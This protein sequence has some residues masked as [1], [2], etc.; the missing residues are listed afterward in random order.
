MNKPRRVQ[1]FIPT[2]PPE[3]THNDL[4]A[5][6]TYANCKPVARIRKSDRLKAEEDRLRPYIAKIRPSEPLS[7]PLRVVWKLVW[8]TDGKHTQGE[9]KTTRPDADNVIKTLNDLLESCHVIENDA[10]VCDL[11]VQ[12]MYGDPAGIWVR[13]EEIGV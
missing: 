10:M 1:C 2:P 3:T 9:A 6:V 11:S 8:P 12:K 5:Y 7:G 13:V 4:K